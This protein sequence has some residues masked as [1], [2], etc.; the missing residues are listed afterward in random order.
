MTLCAAVVCEAAFGNAPKIVTVSD[1]MISFEQYSADNL[2]LK[3]AP[4]HRNWYALFSSDDVGHVPFV[5]DKAREILSSVHGGKTAQQV[6]DAFD[7]AMQLRLRSEIESTVLRR[8]GFNSDSFRKHG[9][10]DLT[11]QVFYDTCRKISDIS[12]RS[13]FLVV[14][15]DQEG[16]PHLL[17]ASDKEAPRSWS[18]IGFAA[19]GSG[20]QAALNE[21]MFYADRYACNQ[22]ETLEKAIYCAC[23][24]KFGAEAVKTV[25]SQRTFVSILER[26]KRIRYLVPLRWKEIKKAWE[27]EGRS[28][29]PT[30]ICDQIRSMVVTFE[31]IKVRQNLK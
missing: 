17:V 1:Q 10:N 21:L 22:N 25:G 24:A 27:E 28:R 14:G 31:E 3:S 5:L 26:D 4:I 29:I 6:A 2:A 30:Q 20:A 9:K 18:Q 23:A 13:T 11:E 16:D 8:L 19:I 15:F 12:L 7:E